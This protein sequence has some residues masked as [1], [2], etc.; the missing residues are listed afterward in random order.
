MNELICTEKPKIVDFA[1]AFCD[2]TLFARAS[3][4]RSPEEMMSTIST[5]AEMTGHFVEGAGG[6]VIK[7]IGDA[8]L[9]VFPE[10]KIDDGLLAL[11]QLKLQTDA[12]L[13]EQSLSSRMHIKV[14]IGPVAY[15]LV[16]TK[17]DKRADVIGDTVNIA[18]TLKSNG[19]SITPQVF[20]KLSS[21]T[22]KLYKKHT[23]PIRYIPIEEAHRD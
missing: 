17:D 8:S 15:G 22:R 21:E 16:G 12:W 3:T 5:L 20:R 18:A 2:L 19:I 10:G 9:T 23:P 14:H 13:S 1:V 4:Q 7:F 11:Q 6:K